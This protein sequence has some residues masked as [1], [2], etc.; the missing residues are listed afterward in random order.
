MTRV[1]NKFNVRKAPYSQTNRT[2]PEGF[3]SFQ[4]SDKEAYLQVLLTNTLTGT[5][6]A[7]EA[8]LLKESLDLHR[9]MTAQE[10]PFAARAL[11]Y[12]RR[13]GL[14]RLQPIVGLAHLAKADLGLFHKVFS[15]V[16]QTPGDLTDF[17]EIVRGGVAPGGMGR[18]IKTA[19]NLWLNGLSEYHAI[20]YATGGQGYSLRDVLRVTHPKPISP[21][22]DAIFVWLT[23][24]EKWDQPERQA[25]TPQIGAFEQLKCLDASGDQAAV[26]ALIAQ[27]R[28]PYEVVT[29]VIKPDQDTWVELMRQM[30]FMALLRHLNTLQRAGVLM[31]E[32]HARYV[33]G[34]L[35]NTDALRKAKILPFQLFAS[36]RHFKAEQPAERLVSEALAEA[37]DL[38][39]VNLPDLGGAICIAPDVSGSMSGFIGRDNATRYIDIAGIFAGALLKANPKALVLPFENQVVEVKLSARDTLVTT[40]NKLAK[41]GG[42]GTAVSAPVSALLDRKIKVDTF[43]G[44]T[45]NIEWA[46]DQSGRHGFLP[47]WYE[48]KQKVAP[49][50]KAFL[51]TIAPYRHAIA[52]QH[53]ADIYYTYGWNDSVL[54][55]IT[56]TLNGLA[57]QVEAVEQMEL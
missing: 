34:R 16:I 56:L 31:V 35:T 17:V 32:D 41:I 13:E 51:L 36:Y 57:G 11:V 47:T 37:M 9:R 20:K 1:L 29:G 43:I 45:D 54:R 22:Q 27:G 40:A 12:A 44:I 2:N 33:V 10:S 55:Y 50:A 18:S 38:A 52:P 25:L 26:R 4:R 6:Y 28:L 42:G 5:F 39:F 3:P 48:Y 21:A 53:A 14:M 8:E 46:A 30:P 24:A 49:Q 23:D 15:Q 7:Q 19:I